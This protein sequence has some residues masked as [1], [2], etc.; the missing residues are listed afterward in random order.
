MT[1]YKTLVQ[2]AREAA[3]RITLEDLKARIERK[4]PILLLDVREG[5]EIARGSIPSAVAMPRGVLERAIEE[6]APDRATRIVV[7]CGGGGRAA[8]AA[9]SLR[10]LGYANVE[11][12]DPGYSEWKTRGYPISGPARQSDGEQTPLNESKRREPPSVLDALARERYG[13]QLLLPEVGEEGQLRLLASRVL[14]LGAGGLGS[15]ALP[16][17]AGAGVGTLGIADGDVVDRSNLHRQIMHSEDTIGV[18]KVESA[19]RRLALQNPDVSVIP[20]GE[21]LVEGNADRILADY[22]LVLDATDNFRTRY[23]VNDV[24]VRL[25]VPVI[26]GSIFRFEGQA[27]TF[28]PPRAAERLGLTPGPC[29]RCLFPETP[30]AALGQSCGEIGVLGALCGV[31]GAIQATE[32]LK[33]LLGRGTLL[34]GRLLTYDALRLS[35]REIAITRDPGCVAC[36]IRAPR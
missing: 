6:R 12:V 35:F 14:V 29:Y 24:A 15:A 31:I 26:H 8:L 33:L 3:A 9:R 10:E 17:L 5:E 2:G 20:Y 16:Y 25:G 27:S 22:D 36:G 18:P 13:R 19:R 23:L 11:S 1:T 7:F 34:S 4:E 21:H 30:N 28:L 32:A